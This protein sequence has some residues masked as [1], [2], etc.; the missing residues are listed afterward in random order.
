[1]SQA[2]H[3]HGVE[4]VMCRFKRWRSPTCMTL[5][6]LDSHPISPR[7]RILFYFSWLT[8]VDLSQLRQMKTTVVLNHYLAGSSRKPSS[9]SINVQH[10]GSEKSKCFP[11][12]D[13]FD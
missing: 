12:G 5:I 8:M 6:D 3:I 9:I 11:I 7:L 13:V 1:M 4:A 10:L 2:Q